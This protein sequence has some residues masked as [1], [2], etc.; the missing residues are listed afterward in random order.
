M[1]FLQIGRMSLDRV[2][3][4]I[5]TCFSCGV[6]RNI[7]CTSRLMS[8][9]VQNKECIPTRH[10][11]AWHA[12]NSR[13]GLKAKRHY[14]LHYKLQL[15]LLFPNDQDSKNCHKEYEW[16]LTTR[17]LNFFLLTKICQHLVTFIQDKM[18][19]VFQ[20]QRPG[21]G[22][23]IKTAWSANHNVRAVF[24]EYFFIL[25]NW[26]AS[27]ENSNFN[28]VHVFAEPLILLADLECQLTSMCHYKHWDLVK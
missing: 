22:K 15:P 19:D 12:K 11:Y 28:V 10:D 24:L 21:F 2:A 8:E 9:K 14:C 27:K 1:N 18:L 20:W 4:N 5:I 7:S 16:I 13:Q 3:L 6:M 17:N 26:H 25:L 23:G